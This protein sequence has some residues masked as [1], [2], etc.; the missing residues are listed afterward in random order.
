MTDSNYTHILCI[1]D[2]SGSMGPVAKDMRGGLDEFFKSQAKE[3]GRCLVDYVQ[4]DN[5]REVVFTDKPVALAKAQLD[6]RS[7]TALLDALG[8]SVVELGTKLAAKPE[9]DRPGKVIVV[10]VTDGYENASRDWTRDKV[11]AL[12]EQQQ[13]EWNW[14]FV[15]LGANMDAISEGG[16]LGVS[17]GSSMTYDTAHASQTFGS[18]STY[19]SRARAS[20]DASFT[21]DERHAAVG[22]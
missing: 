17:A 9:D 4:F 2:R 6:P 18:L 16:A 21:D 12:V 14:T 3:P 11:K 5:E 1:V 22:S 7:M 20:G 19:V 8:T 10:V 15:F 13:D